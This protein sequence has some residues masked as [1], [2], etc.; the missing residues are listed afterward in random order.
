MQNLR[1]VLFL[2]ELS[3]FNK[4]VRAELIHD[5]AI[6]LSQMLSFLIL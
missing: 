1:G 3:N 2:G 6:R 4:L 5:K